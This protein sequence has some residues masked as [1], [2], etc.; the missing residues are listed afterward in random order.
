MF[1]INC[2]KQIIDTARF[3]NYCGSAVIH[4]EEPT[5]Q[6]DISQSAPNDEVSAASEGVV[7]SMQSAETE[8]LNSAVSGEN[9]V[10]SAEMAENA[11]VDGSA[12]FA[13]Q[14]T[15]VKEQ[16]LFVEK[17]EQTEDSRTAEPIFASSGAVGFLNDGIIPNAQPIPQRIEPQKSGFAVPNTAAVQ[18]NSIAAP[19]INPAPRMYTIGHIIMCL[20]S[21][22]IMAIAAGVFAGLY[23]S[24]V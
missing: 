21:T 17:D 22:A 13:E 12:E 20:A 2:G 3:C 11:A 8:N 6:D 18:D 23:F 19:Q 7:C 1:C 14:S 4:E 10:N 24:V 5:V 16:T 9:S 15:E